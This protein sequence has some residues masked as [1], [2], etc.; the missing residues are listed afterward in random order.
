MP[1]G[2]WRRDCQ[3]G[4]GWPLI[5]LDSSL[6]VSLCCPDANSAAAAAILQIAADR[7]LITTLCELETVNALG[8]RVFRKEISN[9]QAETSLNHFRKDQ[10]AGVFLLR[11]LP[12]SAFERARQLSRQLTPKLGTRTADLLHVAAALELGA[13]GFF[14]FDMQQRKMAQA[15]GLTLNSLP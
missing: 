14:S 12:E 1:A 7:L 3:H 6:V 13:S 5:Y 9:L 11:A 4:Q 2:E 15:A 10:S 8:L